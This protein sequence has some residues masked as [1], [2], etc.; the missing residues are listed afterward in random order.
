MSTSEYERLGR[1]EVIF[2]LHTTALK[3]DVFY[4]IVKMGIFLS[5][6]LT[7]SFAN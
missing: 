1:P 2:V 6:Y 5:I 4:C 3:E 7:G